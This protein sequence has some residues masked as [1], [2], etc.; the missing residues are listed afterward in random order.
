MAG[1]DLDLLPP[2]IWISKILFSNLL[3][4][5]DTSLQYFLSVGLRLRGVGFIPGNGG[6][7]MLLVIIFPLTWFLLL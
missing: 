7:L 4:S 3:F 6:L 5:R 2:L 1:D